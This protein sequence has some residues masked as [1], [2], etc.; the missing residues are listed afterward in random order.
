M[1]ELTT[2]HAQSRLDALAR[3]DGI[4]HAGYGIGLGVGRGIVD[5]ETSIMGGS[6][7]DFGA[8]SRPTTAPVSDRASAFVRADVNPAV[9]E[10]IRS[11]IAEGMSAATG[12]ESRR[13][14]R[15]MA[16]TIGEGLGSGM[17][18]E[19]ERNLG[20]MVDR[21]LRERF[22]PD[23]TDA[24]RAR[25][26]PALHEVLEQQVG[27]VVREVFDQCARDTLQ[28]AVQPENA[29]A[30]VENSRNA[31]KGASFGN[32]DALMDMGVLTK[33]GKLSLQMRVALWGGSA[34]L[35]LLAA[36]ALTLSILRIITTVAA[37][38]RRRR[39]SG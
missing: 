32:H 14:A 1:D 36:A 3:S 10:I 17:S 27:P 6:S 21:L 37:W 16:E 20:P 31:S 2:R 11:A 28:M 29:P 25:L 9:A 33:E 26:G 30:V 12:P 19:I 8:A 5:E 13:Q 18:R 24:V 23:L 4:Q 34:L 7:A 22:G 39:T 15:A 38:R 35:A